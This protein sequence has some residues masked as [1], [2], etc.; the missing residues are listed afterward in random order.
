MNDEADRALGRRR[1]DEH[2]SDHD[3]L[4]RI[5]E[6]LKVLPDLLTRLVALE[7]WRSEQA[8][9]TRANARTI[10]LI[11]AGASTLTGLAVK[12]AEKLLG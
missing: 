8:G 6:R 2:A 3:L 4:V 11:V 10:A 5:D 9:E 1:Y 12:L 7:T